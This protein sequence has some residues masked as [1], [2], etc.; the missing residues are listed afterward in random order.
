MVRRERRAAKRDRPPL[1]PGIIARAVT[2]GSTAHQGTINA[3][4]LGHD[5]AAYL[6]P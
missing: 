5:F 6:T 1:P 3:T 4:H 2:T